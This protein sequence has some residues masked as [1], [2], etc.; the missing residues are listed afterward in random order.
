MERHKS[1]GVYVPHWTA[2]PCH[3]PDCEKYVPEQVTV[4]SVRGAAWRTLAG[5]ARH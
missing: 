5:L 3:N 1:M 2:G 4:D